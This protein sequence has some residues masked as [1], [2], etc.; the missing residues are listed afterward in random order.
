MSDKYIEEFDVYKNE[1]DDTIAFVDDEDGNGKWRIAINEPIYSKQ[2]KRE[3]YMSLIHELAHIISLNESQITRGI[4]CNSLQVEEGCL[5]K[6]SYLYKFYNNFYNKIWN[7]SE[8]NIQK[9]KEE[10]EDKFNKTFVTDYAATNEVEDFAESFTYF[11][12][13]DDIHYAVP[14]AME[15]SMSEKDKKIAFM[16]HDLLPNDGFRIIREQMRAALSR[17]LLKGL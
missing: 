16:Y 1:K 4:K 15:K 8:D 10:N 5:T 17:D 14:I 9:Y 12:I 7:K 3:Q 2:S 11:V 13:K 6:D